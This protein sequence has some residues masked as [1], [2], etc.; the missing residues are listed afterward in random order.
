MNRNI[1]KMLGMMGSACVCVCVFAC[2]FVCLCVY[3]NELA[4]QRTKIHHPVMLPFT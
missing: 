1:K 3:V 2:V 4:N